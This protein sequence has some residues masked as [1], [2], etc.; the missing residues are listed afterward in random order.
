[1]VPAQNVAALTFAIFPVMP[2]R[3]MYY[4]PLS[5]LRAAKI[6][7]SVLRMALSVS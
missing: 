3:S 7:W 4:Y 5:S 2:I 6:L 1:M